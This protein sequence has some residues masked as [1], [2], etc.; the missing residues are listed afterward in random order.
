MPREVANEFGRILVSDEVIATIAGVAATECRGIVGMA[1]SRLRDGIA[2]LLGRENLSKG[3][4]VRVE[5]DAAEILLYIVVGYGSR[6]SEV[7]KNVTE[8]VRQHVE[9]LTGLRVTDV[10][11]KVQG[12]KVSD[13]R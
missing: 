8:R 4:D 5:G 9:S 2:E 13:S 1:A 12:V 7:A 11:I 3:V 6:I 10:R